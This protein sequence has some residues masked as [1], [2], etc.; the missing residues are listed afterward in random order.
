MWI[1][2]V[3]HGLR[4]LVVTTDAKS[5]TAKRNSFYNI[6][7]VMGSSKVEPVATDG[8]SYG[9][10]YAIS[11]LS[12]TITIAADGQTLFARV[13]GNGPSGEWESKSYKFRRSTFWKGKCRDGQPKGEW[14]E[15]DVAT[16]KSLMEGHFVNGRKHG[17]WVSYARGSEENIVYQYRNGKQ[18]SVTGGKPIIYLK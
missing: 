3:G 14:C 1:R 16:G 18:M 8:M 15:V 17:R 11:R 4:V 7:G 6:F 5:G 12:M 10:R 9:L 13:D 2:A